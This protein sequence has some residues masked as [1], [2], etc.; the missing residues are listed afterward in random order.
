MHWTSPP[1]HTDY[2]VVEA[3]RVGKLVDEVKALIALGWQPLGGVAAFYLDGATFGRYLQAM[4]RFRPPA[5]VAT[6]IVTTGGYPGTAV[7][8]TNP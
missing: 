8:T 5:M 3:D 4:T 7:A 1:D 6:S 2:T